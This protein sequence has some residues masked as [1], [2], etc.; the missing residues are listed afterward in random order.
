MSREVV[1]FKL[2]SG[3]EVVGEK[4]TNL[5]LGSSDVVHL[6]KPFIIVASQQGVALIPVMIT[7]NEDAVVPFRIESMA[8]LPIT[9]EPKFEKYYLEKTSGLI[10]GQ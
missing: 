2:I 1:C 5:S 9:P 7:A 10:L 8:T 3:D 6:R 4:V